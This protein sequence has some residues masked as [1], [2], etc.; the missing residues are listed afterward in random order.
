MIVGEKPFAITHFEKFRTHISLVQ[1]ANVCR[2]QRIQPARYDGCRRGTEKAHYERVDAEYNKKNL[3]GLEFILSTGVTK[4]HDDLKTACRPGGRSRAHGYPRTFIFH[5]M[6]VH[7]DDINAYM[8][9]GGGTGVEATEA[10]FGIAQ[11]RLSSSSGHPRMMHMWRRG[12]RCRLT[13]DVTE[14]N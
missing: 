3:S 2:K 6:H 9:Q 1:N 11:G 7:P 5:L 10:T 4:H 13:R 8:M 12:D 14:Q